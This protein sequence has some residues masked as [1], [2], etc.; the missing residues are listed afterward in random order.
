M[1]NIDKLRSRES[2][3]YRYVYVPEHPRAYKTS[4]W[5]GFLAE[6]IVVYEKYFGVIVAE[7]ECIHHLDG[8]KQNNHPSNLLLLKKTQHVKLHRWIE[9]G[10][11]FIDLQKYKKSISLVHRRKIVECSVCHRAFFQGKYKQK[12][13]SQQCCRKY[14]R[15]KLDVL[16]TKKALISDLK[17][18]SMVQVGKKYNVSARTV[19]KRALAFGLGYLL[20][21]RKNK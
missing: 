3:G 8:N 6:H 20:R 7:D 13:C 11:P 10:C 2:N 21:T 14:R 19:K 15:S 1:K 4:N 18:M 12:F 16:M 17:R 5:K 9:Q